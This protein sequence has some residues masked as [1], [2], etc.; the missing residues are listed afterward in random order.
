MTTSSKL[1]VDCIR[2]P[3]AHTSDYVL[4]CGCSLGMHLRHSVL[5]LDIP[6]LILNV[7]GIASDPHPPT[8]VQ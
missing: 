6:V 7:V 1:H 2:K 5:S 8:A 3:N 4:F